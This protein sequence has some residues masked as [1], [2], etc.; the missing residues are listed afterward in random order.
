[1][2]KSEMTRD[3]LTE[4]QAIMDDYVVFPSDEARDAVVL[5]IAHT[6]VADVFE[7]TPRLGLM[8]NEPASGKTRVLELI[9]HLAP[10]TMAA[11]NV[12]PA[13]LW[14]TIDQ[15]ARATL[16]LDEIDCVFGR[17]GSASAYQQLRSI[18][19][20]GYRQGAKVR[21]CVGTDAVKDFDV[22]APV[23]MAG[24]GQLP[25]TIASRAITINMKR[26]KAGQEIRPFRLRFAK[27]QLTCAKMALE[28]W[29]LTC[30]RELGMIFP[31]MPVQD[32]KADIYEP[33]FAIA[34]LAGGPWPERIKVACIELTKDGDDL[35]SA[36]DQLL[37]DLHGIFIIQ[38]QS[39]MFTV[40]LLD[41]LYD[42]GNWQE[43]QL[44]PRTL[45]RIL[46][47]YG[48]SASTI[49]QGE[50]VSRGYKASEFAKVWKRLGVTEVQDHLD[51]DDLSVRLRRVQQ[52]Y[53][54]RCSTCST[55]ARV[56]ETET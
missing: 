17:N 54:L 42:T 20:A 1:M 43:D 21:R 10:N 33:L 34:A 22:F 37:R 3:V 48:I 52:C 39:S 19:N 56:A 51:E 55:V 32:R 4:I 5:W 16:L 41:A 7:S 27:T 15:S 13:V 23:A 26:R 35:E 2:N 50:R 31:E 45:S 9:E 28:E 12:H 36:T 30:A 18:L 49:R 24:L 38:D 29:A 53:I 8:S 44:D 11:T 25:E 6:H 14:R 46:S 40:D 47:E